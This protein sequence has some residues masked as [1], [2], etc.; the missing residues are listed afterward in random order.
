MVHIIKIKAKIEEI[1]GKPW[2]PVEV[3]KVNDQ[4]IRLALFKGK[5]HWHSHADEDELIF[6]YKGRIVV[7]FKD[8]PDVELAAGELI[9][10]PKGVEHC[11]KSLEDSYVLMFEPAS[12]KSKGD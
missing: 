12:L 7:Q 11:P 1:K 2:H 3:A 9:V 6:V 8:R 10:I 4:V 5:Y